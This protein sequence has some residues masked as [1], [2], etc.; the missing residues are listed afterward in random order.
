M[1]DVNLQDRMHQLNLLLC[2]SSTCWLSSSH[3]SSPD[4]RKGRPS[5]LE[6]ISFLQPSGAISRLMYVTRSKWVCRD[7]HLLES[8][9]TEALYEG[10]WY[11]YFIMSLIK[12]SQ[13]W[14]FI[15]RVGLVQ[16]N[17][18]AHFI[19]TWGGAKWLQLGVLTGL[20][21]WTDQTI[22]CILHSWKKEWEGDIEIQADWQKDRLTAIRHLEN[23]QA[24][25]T[26]QPICDEKARKR[27][28]EAQNLS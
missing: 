24:E 21:G 6:H 23:R 3:F 5:R 26:V 22:N 20:S 15:N 25:N 1:T 10:R 16:I 4:Q 11:W 14:V 8:L 9:F 19:M 13:H 12:G 17:M 7:T 27:S 18:S 2:D 28:K